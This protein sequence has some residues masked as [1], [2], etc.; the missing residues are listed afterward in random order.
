MLLAGLV[1]IR[2]RVLNIFFD[3]MNIFFDRIDGFGLP[4]HLEMI[5][6][7]LADGSAGSVGLSALT[8]ATALALGTSSDPDLYRYQ[9]DYQADAET[10]KLDWIEH[11]TCINSYKPEHDG[12]HQPGAIHGCCRTTGIEGLKKIVDQSLVH[13]THPCVVDRVWIISHDKTPPVRTID[14]FLLAVGTKTAVITN[15]AATSTEV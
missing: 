11:N 5:Q 13:K 14:E 12:T 9:Y 7:L 6:E 2:P 1:H 10:S 3:R 15:A 8:G 4:G